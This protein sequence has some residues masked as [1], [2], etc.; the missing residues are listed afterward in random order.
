MII[1]LILLAFGFVLLIKGANFLIDGSVSLARKHKVS[2][3]AIGL[4]IVAFG[5]S[6]P[7]L[8]VNLFA[9]LDGH[10]SIVLGNIIGSNNF[11]LFVILGITAIISPLAVQSVTVWREIPFSLLAAIAL[12]VLANLF[13]ASANLAITRAES[14]LL[15]SLFILFLYYIFKQMKKTPVVNDNQNTPMLNSSKTW[16]YVVGG[17]ILLV[18]GG[19]LVVDSAVDIA[20]QIGISQ[21][22]I[23]LTI[24][25]AGTSLPELVTSVTAALKKNSDIAVGNIIG[26]NIFNIAL[27]LGTSAFVSPVRYDK[28]FNLDLYMLIAGTLLLFIAMFS[29][30][31]KRLDRWEGV[32]LLSIYVGYTIYLLR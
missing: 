17:L 29:G 12:L 7:E 26:S 5:T 27:I 19:K 9:S 21:K 10:S 28:A 14:L 24:I 30:G 16:L 13:P 2:D 6:M 18:T 8:V 32:V 1:P 15:L 31:N 4:T 3:L 22:V 20:T 23:G 25:A 11:N